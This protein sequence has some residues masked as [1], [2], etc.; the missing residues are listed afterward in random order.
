MH[1]F[2]DAHKNF[3]ASRDFLTE[4]RPNP[5]PDT[6]RDWGG[7][8]FFAT[9]GWSGLV[10]LFPFMEQTANY[11]SILGT[12]AADGLPWTAWRE[13]PGLRERVSAFLCPS[14]PGE[15]LSPGGWTWS[16][17]IARTNYGLCRGEQLFHND[18]LPPRYGAGSWYHSDSRSA[19]IP[20]TRRGMGFIVDGTS[21]TIAM[22]EF[23]KP[24]SL[25][26]SDVRGGVSHFETPDIYTGGEVRRCLTLRNGRTL[27][28]PI[29][30]AHGT[31]TRALR[32][33]HG[34]AGFQ[35]FHTVLPPNSPTCLTAGNAESA[36]GITSTS[37][38][39][40]GGVNAAYFD[41]SAHFVSETVDFGPANAAPVRSGPSQFG[42]WGAMGTP[43]G[44]ESQSL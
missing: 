33:S 16:V 30:F 44:G 39:H 28:N 23:V 2:H 1:N 5:L 8:H 26:S 36:W 4:P 34:S 38:F 17:P 10:F 27:T 43:N 37:S 14:C 32:L 29:D 12:T 25:N 20:I 35:G 18:L 11:D 9:A 21:N 22:G 19:F 31:F 7:D 40:T 42:V 41:G 24:N 6:D 3:P 13:P 15:G